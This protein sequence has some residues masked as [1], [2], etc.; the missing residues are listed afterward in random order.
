M[1]NFEQVESSVINIIGVTIVV[2]LLH[3]ITLRTRDWTTH[4]HIFSI[5]WGAAI[6]VSQ[7]ILNGA[8]KPDSDTLFVL[9]LC[10]WAYLAGSLFFIR[11]AKKSKSQSSDSDIDAIDAKRARFTLVALMLFQWAAIIYEISTYNLAGYFGS[12]LTVG[13]ELRTSNVL[14]SVD[15]PFYLEIWRWGFIWYLPLAFDMRRQEIISKASLIS[16]VFLSFLS[17]LGKF[18]RTPILQIC[19]IIFVCWVILYKPKKSTRFLV[20]GGIACA[21]FLVFVIMQSAIQGQNTS[22]NSMEILA[23]YFGGSFKAYGFILHN[24]FP[25]ES[26]YY[27]LDAIYFIFYKLG[28]LGDY[29]GIIRP[30]VYTP[31][32]TNLYS[33]LDCFTLDLGVFGAFIGTLLLGAISAI[34][35]NRI[36]LKVNPARLSAY[37]YVAYACFMT[38][39]NNEFVRFGFVWNIGMAHVIGLY[40][41]KNKNKRKRAL[42][43]GQFSPG[44]LGAGVGLSKEVAQGVVAHNGAQVKL[45]HS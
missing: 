31:I 19:I 26:G 33:F 41:M 35:Y 8:I 9:Y 38:P 29:P 23:P 17:A 2:F 1:F 34:F 45:R 30:Y 4:C 20:G 7:F 22:Q 25:R 6:F 44:A 15:L 10:W 37:C 24:E 28:I 16:I 13:A 36:N 39:S 40:V 18:T 27:S 12:I 21:I 43:R 42:Q 14:T 5:S 3:L 32:Y 11:K